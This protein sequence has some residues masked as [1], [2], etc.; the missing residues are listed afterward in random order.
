M[1]V[2][3]LLGRYAN[4]IEI[5]YTSREFLLDFGQHYPD[6]SPPACHTR[7][8]LNFDSVK[9]LREMITASIEKYRAEVMGRKDEPS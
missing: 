4:Y 9:V 7:I 3:E 8:I 6:D 1:L 5:R 2:D